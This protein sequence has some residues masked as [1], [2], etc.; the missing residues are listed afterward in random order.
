MQ[1]S[2][3]HTRGVPDRGFFDATV[4]MLAEATAHPDYD[5]PESFLA[6]AADTAMA[7]EVR[8]AAGPIITQ[9]MPRI[10]FMVGTGGANLA[11]RALFEIAA[12]TDDV[13]MG[14]VRGVFLDSPS[15]EAEAEID[16]AV[17]LIQTPEE[18][19]V[20]IASAS[21]ATLETRA[22]SEALIARLEA[23]L[24]SVSGRIIAVT[25]AGTPL[26][27]DAE[28]RGIARVRMPAGL[29]DRFSLFAPYALVFHALAGFD[30]D[31]WHAAA[32]DAAAEA[33]AAP[34]DALLIADVLLESARTGASSIDLFSFD[35]QLRHFSLW[36]RQILAESLG[37]SGVSFPLPTASSGT[38]DLHSVLQMTLSSAAKPY[39]FFIAAA[40]TGNALGHADALDLVPEAAEEKSL[41]EINAG[42]RA[43][44]LDA[45]RMHGLPYGTVTFERMDQREL[46]GAMAQW[47]IATVA[48]ARALGAD[49]FTQPAV[50]GYKEAARDA[51]GA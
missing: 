51:L 5:K 13:L 12:G 32:R 27:Q 17:A 26:W 20:V 4:A 15:A 11:T 14:R 40:A 34:E 31:E 2:A 35:P 7:E 48:V 23:K 21:G 36:I 45:Y 3:S 1:F 33:L 42:I 22:L 24:G 38:T 6:Y 37:K 39:T 49:P 28:E 25:K 50:E 46:M 47:M 19:A 44:A 10:I 43:A 16:E 30:I 8:S 29:S 18:C 9:G 41:A